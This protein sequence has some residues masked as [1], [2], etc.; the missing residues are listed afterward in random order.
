MRI[1]DLNLNRPTQAQEAQK[2]DT[3]ALKSREQAAN[4]QNVSGDESSISELASALT[5]KS[6]MVEKLRV[7]VEKGEYHVPAAAVAASIINELL[8]SKRS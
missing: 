8:G 7:Q 5:S 1:D 3:V 6:A 4:E 2:A